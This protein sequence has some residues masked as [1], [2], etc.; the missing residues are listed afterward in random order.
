MSSI[1]SSATDHPRA[2]RDLV[3]LKFGSSVLRST[4]DLP[5]AVHEIYRALRDGRRVLAVVSAIGDTTDR[6]LAEAR[7][8]VERP[9]APDLARLLAGG[10]RE[11]AALL[12]L[13]LDRAGLPAVALDPGDGCVR[14]RGPVLDAEPVHVDLAAF[15]RAFD[16]ADVV[17]LPGFFAKGES[18]ECVLLGRGGSD[19][20][21]VVVARAL[22]ADRCVLLKD[23]DG[24]YESDPA[25]VGASGAAPRRFERVTFADAERLDAR[26]LQPKAVRFC[27]SHAAARRASVS[28]EIAG[29][30]IAGSEI[31][32]DGRTSDGRASDERVIDERT[33][34][35]LPN[36]GRAS[37]ESAHNARRASA[38]A[39][40]AC[41]APAPDAGAIRDSERDGAAAHGATRDR[42]AFEVGA[43]DGVRHT[44]V[45]AD[46]TVLAA[47]APAAEPLRVGLIGLGTVGASVFERLASLPGRVRITAVL[48]RDATRSRDIGG[49]AELGAELAQVLT[50]DPE[51]F[52]ASD[53]DV[54]VELAGGVGEETDEKTD[55]DA[56]SRADR[57]RRSLGTGALVRRALASGHHVV[58]ANKALVA[59]DGDEL[60]ELAARAGVRL[61]FG[62]AVGGAVPALER[63]RELRARGRRVRWIA[64]V[65]NGTVG[66]V[67]DAL[68]NG[69]GLDAA[70]ARAQER[71]L[72]EADPTLDLDGTDAGHKIV[73]LARAAGA[74]SVAIDGIAA[75]DGSTAAVA[76]RART[77]G[78][79]LTQ[80][81]RVDLG[82][83][84]VPDTAL[85]HSSER[86]HVGDPRIDRTTELD[87]THRDDSERS[88]RASVRLL[89]L[90]RHHP[91]G[92]AR[93]EDN[94]VSIGLDDGETVVLHGRGAGAWPTA[95]AVLGDVLELARS[96]VSR[97]S[98]RTAPVGGNGPTGRPS[99]SNHGA[100]GED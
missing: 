29:S 37:N 32:S 4:A 5:R 26:I 83:E 10:E 81:A 59:R 82:D 43:L 96:G 70:I 11:A 47:S 24:L 21:A 77:R 17:V 69:T 1:R 51:Q 9:S 6:L 42:A 63:V 99:E 65:L 52:F 22:D 95:E 61:A 84:Q 80:V 64:G 39:R 44:L 41:G 93:G 92:R 78:L 36:D 58:T 79:R 86:E 14:A 7:R 38:N 55:V 20:T 57:P 2:P 45:G 30:E 27:A 31:A 87:R 76:E 16:A 68:E 90:D 28:D 73:L 15:A 18:G 75:L 54:V 71:G 40:G 62:A 72:A 33:S 66:F 8:L 50:D 88:A 12:V 98:D 85:D 100:R 60:F 3:V 74:R 19:L 89:E 49:S 48:V 23:V 53:C 67:L 25:L 97:R 34:D 35:A 94:A 46:S 91:L 56:G 13:A